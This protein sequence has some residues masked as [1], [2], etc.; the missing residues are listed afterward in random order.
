MEVVQTV[1]NSYALRQ[2]ALFVTLACVSNTAPAIARSPDA[3]C[4]LRVP[5]WAAR[6]TGAAVDSKQFLHGEVQVEVTAGLRFSLATVRVVDAHRLDAAGFE[7]ITL[8]AYRAVALALKNL[9]TPHA[10]RFWNF[11]PH[12]RTA[13]P[14]GLDRYMVFNA[15][16]FAALTEWFGGKRP[17][18][19]HVATA[20]GVGHEGHDLVIHVLAGRTAGRQVENPR[21]IPSFDYSR[22]YGPVPP[23]FARATWVDEG[24][25]GGKLLI[26]GTSSVCGEASVHPEDA[27]GQTRETLTNLSHL[28]AAA[29]VGRANGPGN[30]C[31]LRDVRVYEVRMSDRPMIE[32]TLREALGADAMA[33]IEFVQ[34]DLCRPELLVEIEGVGL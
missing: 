15:G 20:S 31:A 5:E 34:A 1:E 28:L 3:A 16:R 24:V 17:S 27:A 13:A 8:E 11:I 21:Q 10:L 7:R 19:A 14:G 6:L 12:I 30:L 2:S 32:A 26:G 33:G 29:G 25:G 9:S 23:C 4:L 22:R 18:S